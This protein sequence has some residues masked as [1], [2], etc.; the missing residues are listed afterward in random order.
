MSLRNVNSKPGLP[1]KALLSTLF[2]LGPSTRLLAQIPSEL[3]VGHQKAQYELFWSRPIDK[4]ERVTFFNYNRLAVPYASRDQYEFVLYSI[5]TYNFSKTWGGSAG[6]YVFNGGL[7][8]IA[9]VSYMA[10]GKNWFVN[11]FPTVELRRHPN[12]ELFGFASYT[13]SL[14][15]R[16]RLFTQLITNTNFNFRQH[17]FS[18]QQLRLGVWRN[19]FQ[20]GAGIDMTTTPTEQPQFST[21]TGLFVRKEL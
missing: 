14:T 12:Y 11:L 16:T 10:Q 8:S 5:G 20:V 21:N 18:L 4:A 3:F 13:P 7:I 9:A 1:M 2:T 17:N 15:E 6:G 19:D